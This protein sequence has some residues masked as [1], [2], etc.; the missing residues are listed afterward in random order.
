MSQ[1]LR[2]AILPF[3][4]AF[5]FGCGGA[6]S[7][8]E[9]L[10]IADEAALTPN[11]LTPNALTPNALTPNALTPN[12]L[13]PNA[14]TPNA[15]TPN[16]LTAIK[17]S[18]EGGELSRQ[19]LKYTVSCALGPTQTF[20]F[21]W[22]D[23]NGV[24]HVESFPGSLGL[25]TSWATGPLSADGQHWITACLAA[26]SNWYGTQV[27]I[28]LRSGRG[29]LKLD[30]SSAELAAYPY[31]EG[32]FWGNLF[33]AT[34]HVYSC[35]NAADVAHSRSSL[36]DC[37]AGHVQ[38]DDSVVPCNNITIAGAC[39]D[40]CDAIDSA[41]Q[42]YVQCQDGAGETSFVLTTALS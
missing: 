11:A 1:I 26:R 15:L 6:S 37:A 23:V 17:D 3:A 29:M 9:E 10:G 14:L 38:A 5:L 18:G 30:P 35:Y 12:A 21:T 8:T 32:A 25:A 7:E 28:S 22:T 16:A 19:L 34:P 36:R 39:E 33:A 40:V 42:A 4:M 24:D 41:S 2:G 20:N 27:I 31:V 13:T